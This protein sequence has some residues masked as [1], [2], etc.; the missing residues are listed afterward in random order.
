[1]RPQ[2]VKILTIVC[3]F[4]LVTP[5]LGQGLTASQGPP[6]PTQG[7]TLPELPIDDNVIILILVAIAY[8]VFVAYRNTTTTN[9]LQ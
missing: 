3:F 4:I 7:P 5:M 1:M 9:T 8:G 6:T 2:I